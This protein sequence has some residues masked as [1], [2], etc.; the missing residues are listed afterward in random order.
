MLAIAGIAE[1]A[2]AAEVGA[3]RGMATLFVE[4]TCDAS[5]K[6]IS[7]FQFLVLRIAAIKIRSI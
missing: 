6:T 7:W 4:H 1:D 3:H 2:E 5:A